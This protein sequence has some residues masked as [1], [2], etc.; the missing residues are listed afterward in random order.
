MSAPGG[1]KGEPFT[2]ISVPL[3]VSAQFPSL[4]SLEF[5]NPRISNPNIGAHHLCTRENTHEM[6]HK[7]KL[8]KELS[9]DGPSQ[10]TR[11]QAL[12]ATNQ[13]QTTTESQQATAEV[14]RPEEAP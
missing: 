1:W 2:S 3:F 8:G 10:V 6:P 5:D 14:G 13:K 7:K 11:A 9:I 12:K 4:P